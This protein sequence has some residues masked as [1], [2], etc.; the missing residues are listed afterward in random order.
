MGVLAPGS[1]HAWPSAQSPIDTRRNF[2]PKSYFFCDLKPHE[3]FQNP[4][5]TPSVKKVTQA[6]RRRRKNAINSVH[7]VSW[8]RTHFALTNSLA[9]WA[10]ETNNHSSPLGGIWVLYPALFYGCQ[11]NHLNLR[12]TVFS[13]TNAFKAGGSNKTKN[14]RILKL[15]P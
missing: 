3:K 7:L 13:I 10:T 8:Q 12:K 4:T 11:T 14:E 1:A 15:P 9:N 6:E 2:H 5:I